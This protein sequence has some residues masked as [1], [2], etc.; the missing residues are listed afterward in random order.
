MALQYDPAGPA[1][2][3][4]EAKELKRKKAKEAFERFI[5]SARNNRAS[6]YPRDKRSRSSTQQP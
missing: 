6:A 4:A 5:A 2:R 1:Y 3:K